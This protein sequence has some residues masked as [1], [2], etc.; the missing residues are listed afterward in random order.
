M[1]DL[2][3]NYDLPIDD[4]NYGDL[5]IVDGDLV[6]MTDPMQ[7]IHQTL[8]QNLKLFLG[9]AFVDKSA[10]VPYVQAIVE[11]NPNPVIVQTAFVNVIL[12]T[13]GVKELTFFNMSIDKQAR[14]L[15]VE[16]Q[17]LT[18]YGLI[19]FQQVL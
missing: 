2:A 7:I 4:P 9:E 8:M 18:D 14:Q 17:V 1:S 6:L 12:N 13:P 5:L 19:N 11:K 3:L 15:L 16:F 10:G